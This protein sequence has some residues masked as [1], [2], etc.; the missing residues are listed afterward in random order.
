MKL[1]TS[2]FILLAFNVEGQTPDSTKQFDTALKL[3][4]ES[5][6][7]TYTHTFKAFDSTGQS[8][9]W[10]EYSDTLYI[11]TTRIRKIIYVKFP[12]TKPSDK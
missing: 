9:E 12:Q 8:F 3:Y 4:K 1:I 5:G 7:L 10:K 2:F 6:R 11:D